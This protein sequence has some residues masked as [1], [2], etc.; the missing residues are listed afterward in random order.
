MAR[1]SERCTPSEG[2]RDRSRRDQDQQVGREHGDR[3]VERIARPHGQTYGAPSQVTT[4][5]GGPP[6]LFPVHFASLTTEFDACAVA[7]DVRAGVIGG[8]AAAMIVRASAV[9]T[10]ASS[11]IVCARPIGSHAAS[12]NACAAVI[13]ACAAPFDVCA[14]P[15][16]A[17]AAA[18]GT[19]A[20]GTF[21]C[22][23]GA[24][25]ATRCASG[26]CARRPRA[27]P[28]RSGAPLR[29]LARALD[30]RMRAPEE[31]VRRHV[32]RPR[33]RRDDARGSPHRVR[34]NNHR[35][36]RCDNAARGADARARRIS[37]RECR[38]WHTRCVRPLPS[39]RRSGDVPEHFP[40]RQPSGA[41]PPPG[42]RVKGGS[43]EQ[44]RSA[45]DWRWRCACATSATRTR[46]PIRAS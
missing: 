18:N 12:A 10:G 5:G 44:D 22:A 16:D 32:G 13:P 8:P 42:R 45:G 6:V 46:R 23:A 40:S 14:A 24:G 33:A 30:D 1:P 2:G 36:R 11:L 15:F 25:G 37:R 41:R 17:C 4:G 21:R 34:G 38:G 3:A 26:E 9:A 29:R 7:N 39:D 19:R 35:A 43:Y 31:R 20:G 27:R 28:G